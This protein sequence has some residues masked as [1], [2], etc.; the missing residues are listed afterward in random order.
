M[1]LQHLLFGFILCCFATFTV[2]ATNQSL[3]INQHN[4][5]LRPLLTKD[6]LLSRSLYLFQFNHAIDDIEKASFIER[7]IQFEE[8]LNDRLYLV[9]VCQSLI[10][11]PN[12]NSFALQAVPYSAQLKTTHD[13]FVS[14]NKQNEKLLIKF[15]S[16]IN[17]TSIQSTLLNIGATAIQFLSTNL[18]SCSLP[19]DKV[20]QIVALDFVVHLQL[21]AQ[22]RILNY[23]EKADVHAIGLNYANSSTSLDGTGVVV[24]VGDNAAG[25]YHADTKN[26]II[27]YNTFPVANHGLHTTGT[28]L[29]N[30]TIF[31]EGMGMA[32]NATGISHNFSNVWV[33]TPLMRNTHGMSIT[34]NSYSARVG[35]CAYTGIYDLYAYWLDEMTLKFPDVIHVFAAG[36]DANLN[37]EPYLN[38]FGTVQ[39]SYQSAKN[40]LVVAGS[41]ALNYHFW[42]SSKGPTRDG[43]IK[44]EITAVGQDVFSSIPTDNYLQ[45][46]GTSMACPQ[47]AGGLA[48]ITQRYKQLFPGKMPTSD[49][50]KALVL[51]SATDIGNKGPDYVFGF[52]LLNIKRALIGLDSNRYVQA[53]LNKFTTHNHSIT[54]PPGVAKLKVLLCWNDTLKSV[55][56]PSALANDLNLKIISPT[57]SSYLPFILNANKGSEQQI[58]QPG[59]DH[60]N[61]IEQVVIENPTPGIYT[62]NINASA[63]LSSKQA[64]TLTYQFSYN[65]LAFSFPYKHASLLADTN[66]YINWDGDLNNQQ[67]IKIQYSTD[68]KQSWTSIDSNID[69]LQYAYSWRT[70]AISNDHVFLRI[71]DNNNTVLTTSDTFFVHPRLQLA[72]D[73]NQCPGSIKVKWNAIAS[74]SKYYVSLFKQGALKI[75]DSTSLSNYELNGLSTDSS[76]YIAVSP[77]FTGKEAYR[78][79]ALKVKPNYGT[80]VG[81][82]KNDL[83]LHHFLSPIIGRVATSSAYS[84]NQFLR[85]SIQNRSITPITNFSISYQVD[86]A[87]WQSTSYQQTILSGDTMLISLPISGLQSIGNHTLRLALRNNSAV[88]AVPN[89]DSLTIVLRQVPNNPITVPFKDD[90][91]TTTKFRF[92]GSQYALSSN[93][94]FDFE[95]DNE[96]GQLSSYI[97]DSLTIA[98]SR[99]IHLDAHHSINA[100]VKNTLQVTFNCATFSNQEYRFDFDYYSPVKISSKNNFS[101]YARAVDT[102]NYSLL[103]AADANLLPGVIYKSPSISLSALSSSGFS[104]SLQFKIDQYGTTAIAD[105]QLGSGL[106]VDNFRIYTVTNDIQLSAITSPKKFDANLSA[107]QSISIKIKNESPVVLPKVFIYYN[108]DGGATFKD[109]VLNCPAR[110]PI[111]ITLAKQF[112]CSSLGSHT[113]NVWVSADGDTYLLNDSLLNHTFIHQPLITSFPYLENFERDFGNYYAYGTHNSWQ[114]GT[115]NAPEIPLAA[116]GKKAWKTNL[117]GFYN[118]GENSYLQFPF[119]NT[120]L[121]QYPMLSL[122]MLSDIENCG[123]Q[124][125]DGAWLEY[126][127]NGLDWFKLGTD[128]TGYNWYQKPFTLFNMEGDYRW[129]VASIDLPQASRLQLRIVFLSDEGYTLEGLAIDDI[130][131]FD[132]IYSI[133]KVQNAISITKAT[134]A[135][136][137]IFTD[138]NQVYSILK[139]NQAV[140]NSVTAS[141]YQQPVVNASFSQY[142][143]SRSFLFNA[144]FNNNDSILA[145]L[146]VR[147][148]DF[149]AVLNDTSGQLPCKPKSIY[150]MGVSSY[151]APGFSST[152]NASLNDNVVSGFTFK[153]YSQLSWVPYDSGYYVQVPMLHYGEVWIHDGG[154]SSQLGLADSASFTCNAILSTLTKASVQWDCATRVGVKNFIVQR[155]TDMGKSY[156]TIQDAIANTKNTYIDSCD[157]VYYQKVYYRVIAANEN[158]NTDSSSVDSVSIELISQRASA[159]LFPNPTTSIKGLHIRFISLKDDCTIAVLNAMGQIVYQ[160]LI[161]KNNLSS[162]Y[163]I[164]LKSFAPGLYFIQ[165]KA[166]D[167]EQRTKVLVH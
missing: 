143:L 97:N 90:F 74:V 99:S 145:Q 9:Y 6:S 96:V 117:N 13:L 107:N 38:G 151:D 36:N 35:D 87:S 93:E 92:T 56:A 108:L 100:L 23:T 41:N 112:D 159:L 128:S 49:L 69:V 79:A 31:Q 116:S 71:L 40:P 24:G 58:A 63:M 130:H 86:N 33:Q 59:I 18:L 11:D 27:N 131:I 50:L 150:T 32:P 48:L 163:T 164:D 3:V 109:S 78:S 125:C 2:F 134:T 45:A 138:Q 167:F 17:P 157:F 141:L 4:I 10:V 42:L 8:Q 115:I 132:K 121:L 156:E 153:P 98:G 129:K 20:K 106:V 62:S 81:F 68:Y 91:E 146:Y 37:C 142:F 84:A 124:L 44:P 114:Y 119:I 140:A 89:N 133:K 135:N 65:Q 126:S 76:Y 52:G 29:G 39:G 80:C 104:S 102:L 67:K 47:V 82:T 148:S 103:Y 127:T 120:S 22:D 43:R 83:A 155:S 137:L 136:P 77:S 152:E 165:L 21:A 110:V 30:G 160:D 139:L 55:L 34:N 162:L 25:M 161:A 70:P 61:N 57:A 85:F 154:C 118:N 105:K 122:S 5:T 75:I 54:V 158:G 123:S 73:S 1:R 88:D 12:W 64:Y 7:G 15:V 16:A 19:L 53:V 51:N 60:V 147:D 72:L 95:T 46:S 111:A 113:L 26:R 66:V 166:R 14:T 144:G 94:R 149:L 28:V 101:V